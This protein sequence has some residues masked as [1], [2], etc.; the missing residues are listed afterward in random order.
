M[1]E[2]PTKNSTPKYTSQELESALFYVEELM[3]RI[4]APYVLLNKT[5][6][7]VKNNEWLQGDEITIGIQ[8]NHFGPYTKQLFNIVEPEVDVTED[9][10]Y[11]TNH[12]APIHIRI[13]HK[14]FEFFKNPDV[15]FYNYAQYLL[16]NPF[17]KYWKVKQ[18]V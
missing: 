1:T 17:N 5:A 2:T 13:I 4:Q 15:V 11:I 18:L 12:G 14:K 9:D 6:Y 10:I 16:P 8:K 3:E 7:Q